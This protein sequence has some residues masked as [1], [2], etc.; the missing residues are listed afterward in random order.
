M[1]VQ[2]INSPTAD[3]PFQNTIHTT[4]KQPPQASRPLARYALLGVTGL[5]LLGLLKLNLFGPGVT[6][7]Y[8]SLW[9]AEEPA[10]DKKDKK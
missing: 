2:Y 9:R 1:H 3:H 5:T 7:S 8:K 6:E 10:A 4:H